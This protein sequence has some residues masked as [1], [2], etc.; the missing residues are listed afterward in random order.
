[1][2]RIG[3]RGSGRASSEIRPYQCPSWIDL[4]RP[5]SRSLVLAVGISL[6]RC[7]GRLPHDVGVK[8]SGSSASES[9]ARFRITESSFG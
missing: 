1:V 2:G 9:L 4:K 8:N 7:R 5:E 3:I 6:P